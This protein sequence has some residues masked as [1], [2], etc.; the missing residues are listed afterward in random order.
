MTKPKKDTARAIVRD[1]A[2][3]RLTIEECEDDGGD[4]GRLPWEAD[5][6][7]LGRL[8]I[9]ARALVRAERKRKEVKP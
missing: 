9:R 3:I 6:A 4:V 1:L 2:K 7:N 8:C 5:E